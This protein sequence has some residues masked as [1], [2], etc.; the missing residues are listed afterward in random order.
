MREFFSKIFPTKKENKKVT[1]NAPLEEDVVISRRAFLG[2]GLKTLGGAE[3]LRRGIITLSSTPKPEQPSAPIKELHEVPPAPLPPESHP[4]KFDKKQE[5]PKFSL[6]EQWQ[7]LQNKYPK[8]RE[9]PENIFIENKNDYYEFLAH[10]KTIDDLRALKILT[11]KGEENLR[12]CVDNKKRWRKI[13]KNDQAA[14]EALGAKI[15][16]TAPEDLIWPQLTSKI[17]AAVAECRGAFREQGIAANSFFEILDANMLLAIFVQEIAPS[18]ISFASGVLTVGDRQRIE[19]FRMLLNGG[20][21]ATLTPAA[22]DT[23]LSY[24]LPQTT[25]GTHGNLLKLYKQ[26]GLLN[27][28]FAAQCT[29]DAQVKE[30]LLLAHDN[31]FAFAKIA[32][33]S[34]SFMTAWKKSP[35][36]LQKRF[37]TS[38]IAAFHNHGNRPP[39]PNLLKGVLVKQNKFL[40]EYRDQLLQTLKNNPVTARTAASHARHSGTYFAHLDKMNPL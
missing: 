24:G 5:V 32:N 29:I 10:C 34:V 17:V 26:T 13:I 40:E 4:P 28:D 39:M 12:A 33:K 23:A 22:Y 35:L 37:I 20:W 36:D 9:K 11:K 27:V 6:A 2:K 25:A 19:L 31:L 18:Q 14:W 16:V 21:Q 30:T 7:A 3:L 1:S 8:L 15:F 38:V